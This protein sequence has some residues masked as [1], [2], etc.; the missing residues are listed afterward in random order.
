M[1]IVRALFR[2]QPAVSWLRRRSGAYVPVES[3]HRA[4]GRYF[5]CLS[6]LRTGLLP[7][8][9]GQAKLQNMIFLS[10]VP[11]MICMF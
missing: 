4:N 8:E 11:K 2:E 7:H 3:P 6:N 10:V 9:H 1:A 5:A